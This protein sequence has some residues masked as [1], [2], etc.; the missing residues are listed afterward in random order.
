MSE[1]ALVTVVPEKETEE[2]E[3]HLAARNTEEMGLASK[4]LTEWLTAKIKAV[5]HE[6]AELTDA[7]EI[8]VERKWGSTILKR[9]SQ[10]AAVRVI[11]YEKVLAAV[12][13]GYTIVP[14]FPVDLFAI[15]VKREA[16]VRETIHED[17]SWRSSPSPPLVKTL[18]LP[19][20]E[21]RYVAD[22]TKG[23]TNTEKVKSA[24][25]KELIRKRFT[26]REYGEVE[27]PI[28]CARPVVMEA[29]AQAMALNVFDAI[30]ICPQR[31][32][33]KDPLIIGQIRLHKQRKWGEPPLVSFLIAWHLDLRTL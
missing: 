1:T 25:G 29:A 5:K 20:S 3:V 32:V 15:R 11:F 19:A 9:H 31:N 21:G 16:P 30:G 33:R 14:N 17:S 2:L 10:L 27:F 4:Q 26:V 23:D 6:A 18:A 8:A 7:Y 24:E 28:A 13:A 12:E 22:V